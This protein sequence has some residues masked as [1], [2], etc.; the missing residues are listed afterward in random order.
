ME[1]ATLQERG[2]D[3]AQ[4]VL[5]IP[6]AARVGDLAAAIDTPSLVLDLDA[7]ADNLRTMQVLADRH[8]VALRPHANAHRCTEI[9]LRQIALG[10]VRSEEHT[11]ELQSLMRTSSAVSCLTTKLTQRST[12]Q[13][14]HH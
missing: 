14:H 8:G 11:S 4:D 5:C 3:P 2:L 6:P 13:L 9:A 7:F 1:E 10:A 12:N